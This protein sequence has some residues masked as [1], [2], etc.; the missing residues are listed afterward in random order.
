MGFGAMDVTNTYRFIGFGDIH[1]PK[2][3]KFIG[4]RWAAQPSRAGRANE[5]KSK[6]IGP[7]GDGKLGPAGRIRS[8]ERGGRSVVVLP[9]TGAKRPLPN[10]APSFG[11]CFFFTQ[12]DAPNSAC[13]KPVEDWTTQNSKRTPSST[14]GLSTS[15]SK[16]RCAAHG[17]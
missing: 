14:T 3:Y 8:C 2:P 17:C 12:T 15:S 5:P 16:S 6:L 13:T 1:G 4:F 11:F 9:P 7:S 10:L